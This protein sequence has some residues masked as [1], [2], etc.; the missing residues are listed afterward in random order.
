MVKH[1]T[2]AGSFNMKGCQFSD[3]TWGQAEGQNSAEMSVFLEN[4]THRPSQ[5]TPLSKYGHCRKSKFHVQTKKL[6][7]SKA[8]NI[9]QSLLPVTIGI[10]FSS[11]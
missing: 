5:N 10:S 6:S 9:D 8:Q 11:F 4:V 1:M 7:L 3:T 2:K